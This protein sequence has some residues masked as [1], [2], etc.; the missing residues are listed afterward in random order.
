MA[1]AAVLSGAAVKA[2]VI[3]LIRFM[4]F[5]AGSVNVGTCLAM[6]G[7][8]STFYGVAVGITRANPKTI[9]AYSS[10]SQMGVIATLIGTGL[11][12]ANAG[13]AIAAAFYAAHHVLVKGGLFLAAGIGVSPAT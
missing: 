12:T 9:L 1:A 3:G 10:I 13:V 2:G 7:I 5:D 11:A 4:P 6:V 8:V